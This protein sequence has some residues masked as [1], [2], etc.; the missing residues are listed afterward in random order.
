MNINQTDLL[1]LNKV[2]TVFDITN[3]INRI[4]YIVFIHELCLISTQPLDLYLCIVSF[5]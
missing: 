4:L 1:I 5:Y 3:N 2:R